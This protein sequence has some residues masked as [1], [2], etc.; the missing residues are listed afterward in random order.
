MECLLIKASHCIACEFD[1]LIL[2]NIAGGD[3]GFIEK[4]SKKLNEMIDKSKILIIVSHDMTHIR[5]YCNEVLWLDKG[6]LS[7]K[8]QTLL[9]K[10]TK[11]L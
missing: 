6:K 5:K 8:A 2:D 10:N 4:S 7:C 1:A 3:I 11:K 9:L